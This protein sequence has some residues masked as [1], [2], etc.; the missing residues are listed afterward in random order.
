MDGET[1]ADTL[2]ELEQQHGPLPAT[3][4]C[5][6]GGGGRHLYFK[7]PGCAIR[8]SA[9]KLGSHLDIRGDGG[10]VIVPPSRHESGQSYEW[11]TSV[12]VV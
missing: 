3:V 11:V 1:G 6:T 2:R 5:L 4:E 8:N 12:E 10:Y 7:H 9:G